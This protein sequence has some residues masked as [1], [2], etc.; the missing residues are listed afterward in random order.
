MKEKTKQ[1]RMWLIPLAT[2]LIV[3]ILF[4]EVFMI[5]VVPTSSMEPTIDAGSY[6][7]GDNVEDSFD[8]RY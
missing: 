2:M 1:W 5:G 4:R 8:S 7:L 3:I 6:V